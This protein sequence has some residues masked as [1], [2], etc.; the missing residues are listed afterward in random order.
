M[1]GTSE[2]LKEYLFKLG[3]QTDTISLKKFE[4]GLSKSS[5]NILKVGTAVAGV[6]AAV[7]ASTAAFA[8]SMRKVYFESE[9]ANTSAKN[10]KALGYAGKQIGAD[11]EGATKAMASAVRL[12]PGLQ[13]LIES[14]GVKVTGRDIS[15]VMLDFVAAT[16]NMP[17]FVGAQYAGMFG[18]D[19]D[20]YHQMITHLD[21]LNKKKEESLRLQ[22]EMGIDLDAQKQVVM[23]YTGTLDKMQARFESLGMA[24]MSKFL[25]Q[26]KDA[27]QFVDKKLDWWTRWAL[28]KEKIHFDSKSFK[29]WALHY[30]K[31]ENQPTQA[32]PKAMPKKSA[33]ASNASDI[34]AGLES[35]YSLPR[36]LLDS[37]WAQESSRGK[38]MLSPVGAKGHFQFM[39]STAKQYNLKNPFDLKESGNAASRMYSYLLKKYKGTLEHALA[40]YNWGEGNMDAFLKTGKGLK[41]QNMPDETKNYVSG[42]MNRMLGT[43][44][45]ASIGSITV[46]PQTTIHVN[47]SDNAR[48]TASL[49]ADAQSRVTG[50]IVRNMEGSFR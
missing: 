43:S 42:I 40:A 23:E 49:V 38:H 7:E 30:F 16:K 2:V 29:D 22:R 28:G 33:G 17:E 41:G 1:S 24:L 15:D 25:P 34:F 8:Y 21:E 3:Y 6:V 5:K 11:L 10:L 46:A 19:P 35:K 32:S 18:I 14:F 50:D 9:L 20:T 13:G 12:N 44:N 27:T 36:G 45:G 47:G 4:D 39:D 31:E 48:Q 37:V 26:F